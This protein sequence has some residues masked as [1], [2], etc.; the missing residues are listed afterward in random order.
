MA[1]LV[2]KYVFPQKFIVKFS[3]KILPFINESAIRKYSIKNENTIKSAVV[4]EINQPLVI[5]TTKKSTKLKPGQVIENVIIK[6]I[7]KL[8][9]F[10]NI[11]FNFIKIRI[12]VHYCGVNVS[13]Y[14]LSTGQSEVKLNLPFVPGFEV[15][16][17]I[18]E[19]GPKLENP[20][21]SDSEEEDELTVG[22]RVLALNKE[23]LH[24]FSTECISDQQVL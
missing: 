20:H 13:D 16:G 19:I 9:L 24:G 3:Q 18:L 14:F 4:K 23:Y 17:E 8:K 21:N 7:V 2:F 15:S 5:E 1:L 11:L 12:G 6:I 10:H 22:D